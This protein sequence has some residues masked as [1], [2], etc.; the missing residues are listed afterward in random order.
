MVAFAQSVGFNTVIQVGGT[1]EQI[2]RFLVAGIPVIVEKAT[3]LADDDPTGGGWAGHYTIVTGYSDDKSGFTTQDSLEGPN[4]VVSYRGF[5]NQWRSFN[6]LYIVIYPPA[7]EAEVQTL[8]GAEA[9]PKANLTHAAQL[10]QQ[11][12]KTLTGQDQAFAWFNLGSNL[13]ELG[14][15]ANAAAA[16][17]NARRVGLPWRMLWYQFGPYEA[18]YRVQRYQDVMDLASETLSARDNLE[19]SYYYRGMARL[20]LGDKAGAIEDWKSALKYN[21]NFVLAAKQLEA[22]GK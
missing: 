7:R 20:A 21:R 13:I 22:A 3:L 4:L 19:E 8:L 5:L 14:D 15:P 16:F 12:V 11:E 10:A 17:D 1:P 18:Y 9:D 6:Y 2:K